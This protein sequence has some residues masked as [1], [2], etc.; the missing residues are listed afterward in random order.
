MLDGEISS[1]ELLLFVRGKMPGC[2]EDDEEEAV[3]GFDWRIMLLLLSCWFCRSCF[4]VVGSV[5]V[6]DSRVSSSMVMVLFSGTDGKFVLVGV[7]LFVLDLFALV[8]VVLLCCLIVGFVVTLLGLN[9]SS[10]GGGFGPDGGSSM[11]SSE[12]SDGWFCP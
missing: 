2:A 7:F 8:A 1:D 12:I 10:G 5:D 4:V 11:L 6:L 9:L 3:D